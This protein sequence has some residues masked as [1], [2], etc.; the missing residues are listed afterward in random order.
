MHKISIVYTGLEPVDTTGSTATDFVFNLPGT[1]DV[2]VLEDLGAGRTR[3]KSLNGT[4]EQTLESQME[5][6]ARAIAELSV[7]AD[8]DE[9]IT[10]FVEKRKAVFKGSLKE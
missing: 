9:G 1:D 2:A 10:A 8:G 6:E 7:S 4:F 5:L 3:L